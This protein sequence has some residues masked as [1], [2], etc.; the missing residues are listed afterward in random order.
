MNRPRL[1]LNGTPK[2]ALKRASAAALDSM[3]LEAGLVGASAST[4]ILTKLRDVMDLRG[5]GNINRS[6]Q[7]EANRLRPLLALLD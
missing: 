3:W 7:E 4:S 6:L 1:L 2:S 5:D